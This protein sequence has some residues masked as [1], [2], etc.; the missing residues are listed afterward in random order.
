MRSQ[1]D[2]QNQIHRYLQKE[3]EKSLRNVL[4]S[5]YDKQ[6]QIQKQLKMSE[7]Q[8]NKLKEQEIVENANRMLQLERKMQEEKR[9]NYTRDRIMDFRQKQKKK[10][11]ENL[12]EQRKVEEANKLIEDYS[13]NELMREKQYRDKYSNINQKMQT[14]M[15]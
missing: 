5:S 12:L 2:L 14:H 9:D 4:N 10:E 7:E 11:F 8:L 3:D 6:I 13:N 1:W 15:N